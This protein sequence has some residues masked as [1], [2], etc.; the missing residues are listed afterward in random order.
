MNE[1]FSNEAKGD[2]EDS[3][4]AEA[5][6]AQLEDWADPIAAPPEPKDPA[7][8]AAVC[9]LKALAAQQVEPFQPAE[10]II[11]EVPTEQWISVTEEAILP[12]IYGTPNPSHSRFEAPQRTAPVEI[13][14]ASQLDEIRLRYTASAKI[15]AEVR[16]ANTIWVVAEKSVK[17]HKPLAP[18]LSAS[19]DR[20]LTL[21]EFSEEIFD[22]FLTEVTGTPPVKN[23]SPPR[24]A[25]L[26]PSA[27]R[28]ARRPNQSADNYAGRIARIV[29]ETLASD[30]TNDNKAGAGSSQRAA[31][32]LSDIHGM[33][34]VIE[35]AQALAVDLQDYRNGLLEWRDVNA[36]ALLHGPSGTGKTTV[37]RS[38]SMH[39]GVPFFAT[40]YAAWQATGSGHLGCVTS[41]IRDIFKR[42]RE[43]APAILFIDELDSINSRNGK[44]R[45][46]DWWRAII[47][48]LLEQLDGTEARDGVVVIG[49]TND[50]DKID[51]AIRRSGRLD[52]QIRI[53]FP[54]VPAL[55]EIFR[56]HLGNTLDD[57]DLMRLASISCG[58]TGAD[59]ER[60]A[61]GA[62]RRARVGRRSIQF[63]DVFIELTGELPPP[64]DRT[65]WNLAVHEAGHA[66]VMKA[67]QPDS[68]KSVSIFGNGDSAGS[69]IGRA[70]SSQNLTSA[71]VDDEL[72]VLLAGRASEEVILNHCTG[73]CGG[74]KDSDLAT[75]TRLV[76]ASEASLGLGT[77]GLLWSEI[78]EMDDFHTHFASRPDVAAAAS[79]RLDRSY[80]RAKE[81]VTASRPLIE[82]IAEALLHKYILTA[83]EVSDILAAFGNGAADSADADT[84]R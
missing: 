60:I 15:A 29:A 19:A 72:S 24:M 59:V 21:P 5:L 83:D 3:E 7:E 74:S 34:Q 48:T 42:A 1:Q 26:N 11:L 53:G 28:L 8:T 71:M 27:L 23:W 68:L 73:G 46:D 51:S 40:S 12:A 69:T 62:R 79:G 56:Y 52:R 14:R 31:P 25:E 2:D 44:T 36:G 20:R 65:L 57:S 39:C 43:A 82:A 6:S 22:S 66:I 80:E 50:P 61:R 67:L 78:P 32:K 4:I 64:G 49:A 30:A 84:P 63:N 77:S 55:K 54:D 75:A 81:M 16:A 38:I 33:P 18:E 76:F 9:L 17:R 10:L 13:Y 35:W 47:N 41:A 58:F 70:L 45:H 37:A